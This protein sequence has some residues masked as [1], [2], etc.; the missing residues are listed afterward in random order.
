M[1]SNAALYLGKM[2]ANPNKINWVVFDFN[3]FEPLLQA[4]QELGPNGKPAIPYLIKS[5]GRNC[6]YSERALICIGPDNVP[7]LADKLLATLRDTK[8]PFYH[9]S[10]RMGVHKDS[11]F[12]IRDQIL[13]VFD[14]M[15]TNAEAALP[16]LAFAASTNLPVYHVWLNRQNLYTTL[17]IVGRNHPEVVVPTLLKKFANSA[18]ERGDIAKAIARWEPIKPK[19]SYRF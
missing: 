4:F 16:A 14:R 18:E 8:N 2:M 9:G 10:I 6:D 15:G 13:S 1:G 17:A 11:G 12:F 5:L 7:P 19:F 3:Y